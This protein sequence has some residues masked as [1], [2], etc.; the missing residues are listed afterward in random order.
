MGRGGGEPGARGRGRL[1]PT[2]MSRARG[3]EYH[4]PTIVSTKC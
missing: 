3:E 1:L 2:K 4:V